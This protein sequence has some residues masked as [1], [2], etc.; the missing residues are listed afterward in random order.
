VEN[1]DGTLDIVG[2]FV[3]KAGEHRVTV[4]RREL[5]A[6]NGGAYIQDAFP[7]LSRD[8]R[9]WLISGMSAEGFKALFSEEE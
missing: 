5:E 1:G 7:H 4:K 2:P 9:E 8:D 6:Y 3:D